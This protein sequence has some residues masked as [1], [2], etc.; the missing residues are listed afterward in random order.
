MYWQHDH[1]TCVLT[2]AGHLLYL[3]GVKRLGSLISTRSR[4]WN[5]IMWQVV[6]AFWLADHELSE[7]LVMMNICGS[8]WRCWLLIVAP[9]SSSIVVGIC[10]SLRSWESCKKKRSDGSR[11]SW[12]FWR[13]LGAARPWNES[14]EDL[15]IWLVKSRESLSAWKYGE[16]CCLLAQSQLTADCLS[17]FYS[18]SQHIMIA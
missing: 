10:G 7:H 9:Y 14:W 15:S 18:A 12:S 4:R 8:W 13:L 1:F 2:Q 5:L 11:R 3:W 17:I 16:T 6:T